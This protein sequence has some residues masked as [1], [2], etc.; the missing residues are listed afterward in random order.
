MVK[1]EVVEVVPMVHAPA[2]P[3]KVTSPRV[4]SDTVIDFPVVVALN[5]VPD[6]CVVK[7][8]VEDAEKLPAIVVVP[9]AVY[10]AALDIW[11]D[12]SVPEPAFPFTV[13]GPPGANDFPVQI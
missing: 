8:A 3:L 11:N 10:V 4:V 1:F 2:E 9:P 7:V 13:T 5:T 12:P 6:A